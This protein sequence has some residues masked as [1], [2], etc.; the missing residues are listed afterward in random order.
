MTLDKIIKQ[1]EK[2]KYKKLDFRQRSDYFRL[3]NRIEWLLTLQFFLSLREKIKKEVQERY[4][5]TTDFEIV[6]YDE[7]GFIEYKG[8][9]LY[10]EELQ[11]LVDN[12]IKKVIT[13]IESN[14]LK[15]EF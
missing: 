15:L 3:Q 8:Y 1:F 14:T 12:Y 11:P 2:I 5:E 4:F 9:H 7:Y 13:E 6:S 10:N